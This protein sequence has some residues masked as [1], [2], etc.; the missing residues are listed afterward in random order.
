M[1]LCFFFWFPSSMILIECSIFLLCSLELFIGK[2]RKGGQRGVN[3][4]YYERGYS[5]YV[6]FLIKRK[7]KKKLKSIFLYKNGCPSAFTFLSIHTSL[8]KFNN[9]LK[10]S[11]WVQTLTNSTFYQYYGSITIWS[12]VLH[13][14]SD[15]KNINEPPKAKTT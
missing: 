3:V 5:S 6:T 9:N 12:K 2:R 10:S 14:F 11:T 8:D 13:G 1:I 15:I 4:S 7:K